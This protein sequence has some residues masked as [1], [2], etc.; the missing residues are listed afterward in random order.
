MEKEKREKRQRKRSDKRSRQKRK[1]QQN[2][3][4]TQKAPSS[5]LP[6][7]KVGTYRSSLPT[8]EAKKVVEPQDLCALCQQPIGVIAS[9]LTAPQ[10]GYAHFD[11][12]LQSLQG[13]RRLGE[14]EKISYIGRGTFAVVR[15]EADG[16]F[17]FVERI[18]WESP[19]AFDA[20]K[21]YVEA[22]KA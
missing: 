7:I 17:T 11:C 14:T 6:Q 19:Q 4:G 3:N 22:N 16:S 2:Q 10:G 15:T 13:E 9:A 20:M 18:A 21:K 8:E 12:V 1:T 5:L